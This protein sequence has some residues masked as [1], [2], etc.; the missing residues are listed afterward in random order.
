MPFKS[1]AQVKACYAKKDARWPCATWAKHTPG[2][3][4]ALPAKAKSPK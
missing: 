3:I 1:K 2:G 4:K